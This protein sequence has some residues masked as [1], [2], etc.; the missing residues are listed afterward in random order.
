MSEHNGCTM[1]LGFISQRNE[2]GTQWLGADNQWGDYK[3]RRAHPPKVFADLDAKK[4]ASRRN[5]CPDNGFFGIYNLRWTPCTTEEAHEAEII[6]DAAERE[7]AAEADA[8]YE[9]LY[10]EVDYNV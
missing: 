6:A 7:E 4:M 8:E 9:R 5:D 2:D 10:G 1:T 3:Y